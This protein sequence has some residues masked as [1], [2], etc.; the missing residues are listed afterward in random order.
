[1][2][3]AICSADP[4]T[5]QIDEDVWLRDALMHKGHTA[6][7]VSW[8]SDIPW[9]SY[10]CA[11]LRSVWGY[12]HRLHEFLAWL[13]LLDALNVPLLNPTGMV[14]KNIYKNLQIKEFS[15]KGIP[16]VSSIVVSSDSRVCTGAAGIIQAE[17]CL[18]E[19]IK[20]HFKTGS[21]FVTKPVISASGDNTVLVAMNGTSKHSNVL[22][23]MK[24]N[25]NTWSYLPNSTA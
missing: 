14:R 21:L 25:K 8:D 3:I 16:F 12:Q 20:A 10:D 7:I 4:Y 13:D 11:I 19:T 9:R 2:D 6:K 23:S 24:Q 15:E 1:M 17:D 18:Q 22:Q 5:D